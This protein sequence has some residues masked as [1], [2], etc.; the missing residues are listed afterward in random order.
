MTLLYNLNKKAVKKF[1]FNT[2][3]CS[4]WFGYLETK[5]HKYWRDKQ[6]ISYKGEP[7]T[8]SEQVTGINLSD[9]DIEYIVKNSKCIEC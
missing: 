7:F 1:G 2:L 6:Y 3:E 9:T 5:F 8:G 4:G